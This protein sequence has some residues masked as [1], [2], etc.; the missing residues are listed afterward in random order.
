MSDHE[1]DAVFADSV[2]DVYERFLVPL[3]FERYAADVVDRVR[4]L[5]PG[6]VLEVAAGT[7]SSRG[8]CRPDSTRPSR[9]RGPT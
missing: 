3:I 6:V 8:R 7:G 9:S 5:S 4:R 1:S 2:P